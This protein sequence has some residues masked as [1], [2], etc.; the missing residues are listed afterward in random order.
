MFCTHFPVWWEVGHSKNSNL[1]CPVQHSRSNHSTVHKH[2]L[3]SLWLLYYWFLSTHRTEITTGLKLNKWMAKNMHKQIMW[4][5]H[6]LLMSCSSQYHQCMKIF[7][8]LL[9]FCL[10]NP[11]I[12]VSQLRLALPMNLLSIRVTGL[13]SCPVVLLFFNRNNLRTKSPVPMLLI[14]NNNILGHT[15]YTVMWNWRYFIKV[16]IF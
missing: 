9:R 8:N 13:N 1:E 11:H 2:D 14:L 4:L 5:L 6:C 16:I 15:F 12:Y 3:F 10:K 7:P